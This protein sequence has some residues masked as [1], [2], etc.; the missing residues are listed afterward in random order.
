[1]EVREVRLEVR[2]GVGCG[3]GGG[4]EHLRASAP[5]LRRLLHTAAYVGIRQDT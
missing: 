3:G 5:Q 4:L 1:M 2:V